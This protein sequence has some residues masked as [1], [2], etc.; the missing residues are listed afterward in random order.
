MGRHASHG[1]HRSVDAV[2]ARA[3]AGRE[4]VGG[5]GG[6]ECAALVR[7]HRSTV[8]TLRQPRAEWGRGGG[9]VGCKWRW[10][11]GGGPLLGGRDGCLPCMDSRRRG[12]FSRGTS[13]CLT[14]EEAA[15]CVAHATGCPHA[16]TLM[17]LPPPCP[18]HFCLVLYCIY[19]DMSAT[20]LRVAAATAAVAMTSL[21]P[22]PPPD[23]SFWLPL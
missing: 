7:C 22:T 4:G 18:C 15:G 9:R 11:T 16:L 21:P 20:V 3:A 10:W 13:K 5:G 19:T 23:Q 12:T 17:Y 8:A 1:I 14:S 2:T 6:D